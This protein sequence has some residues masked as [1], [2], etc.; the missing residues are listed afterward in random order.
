[1]ERKVVQVE[2]GLTISQN[3]CQARDAWR[4]Q[5]LNMFLGQDKLQCHKQQAVLLHS[6][7]TNYINFVVIWGVNVSWCH[8]GVVVFIVVA[9][10]AEVVVEVVLMWLWSW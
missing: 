9:E 7:S 3:P 2:G 8:V 5:F 6:E 1:M 4:M 10:V